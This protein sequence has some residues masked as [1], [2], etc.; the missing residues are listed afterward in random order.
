M[1]DD[2]AEDDKPT[3]NTID[4]RRIKSPYSYPI[5]QREEWI[6]ITGDNSRAKDWRIKPIPQPYK[7]EEEAMRIM[8]LRAKAALAAL[9]AKK[10][11][12]E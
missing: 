4:T 12:S 3:P 2:N 5:A 11:E 9:R 8:T 7:D 1:T 6:T 10:S